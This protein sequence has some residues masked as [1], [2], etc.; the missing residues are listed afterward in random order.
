MGVTG[1]SSSS[2]PY[3]DIN[4]GGGWFDTTAI[5]SPNADSSGYGAFNYTPPTNFLTICTNNISTNG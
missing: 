4:W 2:A 1:R 5:S 3:F